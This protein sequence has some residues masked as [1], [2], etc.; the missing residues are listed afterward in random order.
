[1]S[2]LTCKSAAGV[3]VLV[4]VAVGVLVGVEVAV[5]AGVLVGVAVGAITVVL[6]E[7]ELL[8]RLGSYVSLDTLAVVLIM[9]P[10]GVPGSTLNVSKKLALAPE[11]RLEAVQVTVP[12]PPMAGIVHLHPI[13]TM[14]PRNVVLGGTTKVSTGLAAASGPL[15]ATE[16]ALVVF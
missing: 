6:A 8:S 15:F 3:G 16:I 14:M 11:A 10:G 12:K 13:G 5:L 1:M 2:L 9:V 7:A 4:A